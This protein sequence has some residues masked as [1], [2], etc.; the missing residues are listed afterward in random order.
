MRKIFMF[1]SVILLFW[2][3]NAANITVNADITTNTTW[4]NNNVYVLAGGFR[5]VTNNAILTIQPGT[6][7]KSNA[8]A[9]VVTRGARLIAN[10]TQYQPIVFTSNQPAGSRNA[11]DWG[12]ILLLG[13]APINDPAGQRLA[14]GGIDPVKGLYG[15]TNPADNSGSLQY[16]RI[17]YAGIAY[18]P[19]NETNGLTLG[20]VGSATVIN[21]IQVSY[22]GDDSFEWFGGTVNAKYL[23]A[24]RGLDDDFDTDYGFNGKVQFGVSLRDSSIAD[25]SGSNGFESD[26]DATGTTNIPNTNARF[27]NMTLF[28]PKRTNSTT[29]NSNYKRAAHLRRSTQQDIYNSVF[30]GWVNGL[31]IEGTTTGTNVTN[32]NL[33]FKNNVLAGISSLVLD[34]SALSFGMGSWFN[35]NANTI[36]TNPMD[37]M[38]GNPYN[39]TAPT[40]IPQGN[41]PILIGAD[42]TSANLQ[43]PFFTP[44]NYKGAFGTSNWTSCWTEFNPQTQAYT[45]GPI[46]YLTTPV[47]TYSGSNTFCSGIT[48]TLTAPSGFTYLWSTGATTQS[49]V[50]TTSGTFT[51][52]CTNARGCVATS[53]PVVIT[54]TPGPTSTVNV[55]GA[56]TFCTGGSALLTGSSTTP[57]V[58]YQWFKDGASISGGTTPYY[59]AA[60]AGAY[61][62]RVT[63]NGCVGNS[64]TTNITVNANPTATITGTLTVCNGGSTTLSAPSGAGLSYQWYQGGGTLPGATASTYVA[65]A[66]GAY[67]VEVTN[68]NGCTS[69]SAASTVVATSLSVVITAT[70]SGIVCGSSPVTLTATTVSGA[71]YEWYRNG[72]IIPGATGTTYSA[73]LSGAHYARITK[74]GCSANSNSISVGIQALPTINASATSV[75]AGVSAL[76]TSSTGNSYQWYRNGVAVVGGTNPTYS[77][78]ADGAYTIKVGFCTSLP[79]TITVNPLPTAVITAGGPT[80]F[81]LGS[82]VSLSSSTGSGNTYQWRKVNANIPGATSPNYLATTS[83]AYSVRVTTP[84]GCTK[85][86][87]S[88]TVTANAVPSTP[89]ITRSGSTFT[90]NAASGNQWY[91][92]NVL[93]PGATATTYTASLTGCYKTVVTNA[94]GCSNSSDT[95]CKASSPFPISNENDNQNDISVNRTNVYSEV[96]MNVAP[97]PSNGVFEILFQNDESDKEVQIGIYN[98]MGQVIYQQAFTLEKG[99]SSQNISLSNVTDGIYFVRLQS[100]N[101]IFEHKIIINKN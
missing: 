30:T 2:S 50:V 20:G 62:L 9:L 48:K 42:F 60:A 100:E 52:T 97:N 35:S 78:T 83:G 33:Q 70:N 54:V 89:V 4:T 27:S 16:V 79:T 51:V 46:T 8:S 75:C 88:L 94:S 39:Y 36:Y 74:S 84:V 18:Q 31:K 95:L 49:I 55:T 32:G 15:G 56:T 68:S 92:D 93:I 69:T 19:N 101:K 58:S 64:A 43:D 99:Y 85:T 67:T 53:A 29:V 72:Q 45:T 22:G 28:G 63:K 81:C 23:V 82:N 10:G 76:L 87:S 77:T 3:A 11:G 57:G 1:L 24:Y 59:N 47:I 91:R 98:L 66:G 65:N 73:S 12:G 7:I 13:N 37:V 17:E 38:A 14:E 26:N 80:T 34:S 40:F 21:N 61:F 44:V 71:T 6:L 25:I 86:S 41:S 5:Y 90:S 96:S